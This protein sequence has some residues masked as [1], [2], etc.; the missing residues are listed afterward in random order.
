MNKDTKNLIEKEPENAVETW[1]K[2][3]T[4]QKY[5]GNVRNT[6]GILH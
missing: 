4:K 1:K 6:L 5:Q 3:K 2:L